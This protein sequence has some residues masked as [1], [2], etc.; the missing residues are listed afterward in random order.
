[1][2]HK[3][4]P[5]PKLTPHQQKREAIRWRDH[6][7]EPVR[8]APAL[9]I[10][11]EALRDAECAGSSLRGCWP[12][13]CSVWATLGAQRLGTIQL[14]D[15]VHQVVIFGDSGA[16]GE[17]AAAAA[18]TAYRRRG[19]QCDVVFPERG[20]DFNEGCSRGSERLPYINHGNDLESNK[21]ATAPDFGARA[22]TFLAAAPHR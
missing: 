16:A 19:Y 11:R 4:G 6:E 22:A 10:A 17:K 3:L 18:C 2:T 8:V 9:T 5:K 7:G 1:V 21:A 15:V 14:P 13:M 12:T 20:S